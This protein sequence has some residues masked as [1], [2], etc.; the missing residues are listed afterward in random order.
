MSTHS[1]D[2]NAL[3]KSI[4]QQRRELDEHTQLCN[5]LALCRRITA[6]RMYRNSRNLAVYL[7]NDGEIDPSPLI[8]HAWQNRKNVF[9][10]VLAPLSKRLYFAPYR[11]GSRMQLNRFN[12]PEPACAKHQ[13]KL[14]WQLD[15][16]LM[17]LVAFDSSA[18]RIGMGGGFY[19]RSLA[20]LKH[21]QYW[22]KP[23]LVGLAHDMQKLEQI[24]QQPWDVPVDY[25]MTEHASYSA[26]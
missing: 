5:S 15:L 19:D 12:I 8:E 3:R 11:N 10:P 17:P 2:T 23:L 14:P 18:N 21:R 24:E 16:L 25:I 13:W 9:L 26:R 20:Y 22:R 6:S 7:A 4:R 1:P